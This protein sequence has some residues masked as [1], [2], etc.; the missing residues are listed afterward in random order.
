MAAL[1]GNGFSAA[2]VNMTTWKGGLGY[3]GVE[4]YTGPVKGLTLDLSNVMKDEITPIWNTIGIINGTI[5]DEVIVIGNHRDAWLIG[6]GPYYLYSY[7][8]HDTEP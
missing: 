1:N 5:E 4:Y 2:E 3:K 8:G 7:S 6:N